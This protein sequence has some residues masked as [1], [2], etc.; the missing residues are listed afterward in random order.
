MIKVSS[1]KKDAAA[2]ETKSMPAHHA[3]G[4]HTVYVPCTPGVLYAPLFFF[5]FHF[6][7]FRISSFPGFLLS[8]THERNIS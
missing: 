5:S 6:W 1:A 8:I 4:S 3:T 2:S 7:R